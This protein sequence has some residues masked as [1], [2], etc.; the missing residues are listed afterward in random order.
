MEANS[1]FLLILEKENI[2][3]V[4]NE[5]VVSSTLPRLIS[6]ADLQ[7]LNELFLALEG[8]VVC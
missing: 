4:V 8:M 1:S 7:S 2:V 6:S 3:E 5:L